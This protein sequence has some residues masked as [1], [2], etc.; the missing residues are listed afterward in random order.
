MDRIS[1]SETERAGPR[2]SL[3]S[4]AQTAWSCRY[5]AATAVMTGCH[6]C[7]HLWADRLEDWDET[8]S[9]WTHRG[10]RLIPVGSETTEFSA[11]RLF[12]AVFPDAVDLAQVI[13]APGWRRL[14]G[15]DTAQQQRV[16]PRSAGDWAGPATSRPRAATRSRTG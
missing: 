7:G 2:P 14:A 10:H 6:I 5:G 13:G 15:G 11:S 8:T 16:S 3:V 12:A 1:I 9:R 4:V